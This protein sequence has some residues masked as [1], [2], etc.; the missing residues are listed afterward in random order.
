MTTTG[1]T[2]V[3][4]NAAMAGLFGVGV[5]VA[6]SAG[7]GCSSGG[8]GTP[9]SAGSSGSAV[10][11]QRGEQRQRGDDRHR[12]QRWHDDLHRRHPG[13]R[14]DGWRRTGGSGF[15]TVGVCGQ[16]GEAT[17][18]ATT[19]DG[20]EEFFMLS[21]EGL[22]AA[23]CVV[24][25][26][27]KR[28]GAAPCGGCTECTWTQQV[29]YSNPRVMTD[30]GGV[31]ANSDLALTTAKIN[32]IV[33]TR[34]SIGFARELGGAHGSAR[35]KWFDAQQKWDVFGNATWDTTTNL[36]RYDYRDGFC[37]Y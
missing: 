5:L 34:L 23:V 3:R 6:A 14:H 11:R 10:A 17:A 32:S 22:G 19:F 21:D 37:N 24:R 28:V 7:A 2:R 30:T 25:F 36:F 15:T 18:T 27:L 31:C 12:G 9:G 35:M 26:D 4:R 29:E 1:E 20:W 8:S 13:R 16:R 33:G